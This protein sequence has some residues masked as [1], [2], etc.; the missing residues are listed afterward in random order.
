[1]APSV[2]EGHGEF[3]AVLASPQLNVNR[4][5]VLD[6]AEALGNV[7]GRRVL[8]KGAVLRKE[9]SDES[10]L[11][12]N[13]YGCPAVAETSVEGMRH[14]RD[15]GNGIVPNLV[16]GK[17]EEFI[18]LVDY[19]K[20][21]LVLGFAPTMVP[22]LRLTGGLKPTHFRMG[23]NRSSEAGMLEVERVSRAVA[24]ESRPDYS[25]HGS[26]PDASQLFLKSS[27]IRDV[28]RRPTL[29]ATRQGVDRVG[30]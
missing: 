30:G 12:G 11:R 8:H 14:D 13:R 3:N 24:D 23:R 6:E 2:S 29:R 18:G 7:H 27:N 21:L 15:V 26:W 25:F 17:G 28:S 16:S 5:P 10:V 20:G 1:V 19:A 9:A 22:F 4:E